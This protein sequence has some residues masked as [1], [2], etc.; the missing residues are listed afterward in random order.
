MAELTTKPPTPPRPAAQARVEQKILAQAE[1]YRTQVVD[2]ATGEAQ[3]FKS[4]L[5]EYRKNSL[6]YGEAVTRYRLYLETMEKVL[7]RVDKYV[8]DADDGGKVNLRLF[9]GTRAIGS[10]P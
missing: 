10:L 1:A 8:V 2:Q 6:V 9:N 3:A 5:A 7:P 4:M